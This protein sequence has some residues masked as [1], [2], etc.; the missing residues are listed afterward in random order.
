ML[1][2][3]DKDAGHYRPASFDLE[4]LVRLTREDLIGLIAQGDELARRIAEG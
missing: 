4:A 2:N 1:R 3:Y